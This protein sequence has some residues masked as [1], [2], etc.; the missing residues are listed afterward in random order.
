MHTLNLYNLQCLGNCFQ[1]RNSLSFRVLRL[2]SSLA[3]AYLTTQIGI[4]WL[5]SLK[6]RYS[7]RPYNSRIHSVA[8]D[9]R[10]LT[11]LTTFLK[12]LSHTD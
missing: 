4:A 5:Q 1:R 2:Q 11:L 7:L 3:V 8:P 6:R 12:S 10:P 9:S